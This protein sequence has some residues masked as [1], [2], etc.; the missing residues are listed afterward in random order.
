L[1]EG[2]CIDITDRWLA[3]EALKDSEGKYRQ[4]FENATEGIYQTTP[5]GRY[6]RM[7]PSFS[8][9]F[10]YASP[11]EMI[12][13]ITDIGRQLYVNPE[14][15]K[16][17]ARRL[18]EHNEVTDYE[19]EVYRKDGSRF[20]ISI[21]IHTVR[22]SV[23]NILY[24]E[25][26][27]VDIT[28][29]KMAEEETL[30]NTNRVQ[31]QNNA[32]M[33][34]AADESIATGDIIRVF[35]I[36]TKTAAEA[37]EV[38]RASIWL[39]SEDGENLY[40]ADLY[41]A[42]AMTHTQGAILKQADYPNYFTAI[43]NSRRIVAG[44][45]RQDPQTIEFRDGYLVPLG[46]VSML[47]VGVY[48][49]GRLAGIV[50]F[51]HRGEKRKWHADEEAFANAVA[52]LAS[53][54]LVNMERKRA[55]EATLNE[56]LFTKT[57]LDSLPGIFYLYT[58]PELR[59]AR[60]N[61]NHEILLGYGP[62]EINNRYIMDWHIPEA[63][64]AV[65]QAVETVMEKGFD[66]IE[67]PLLSKDGRP[68]PFIMTGVRFDIMGK[69]YLMGV[70][71]D[72]TERKRAEEA[73]KRS[74]AC[75]AAAQ[76]IAHVGNWE[77]DIASQT[78]ILSDELSRILGLE[79]APGVTQVEDLFDIVHPDDRERT[80]KKRAEYIVA[81]RSFRDEYRI[82][83]PDGSIRW[84]EVHCS[85][86]LDDNGNLVRDIGTAQDITERKLAELALCDA[87]NRYRLLFDESPDGILII[88]PETGRFLDFNETAC[89]QLGYSREEFA[90]LTLADFLVEEKTEDIQKRQKRI[91][92]E[93]RD[94]FECRSRTRQGE[95]RNMHVTVQA[96]EISGR[97][98]FHTV[99]RDITESRKLEN[100]L[101]QAQKIEGLGQMAGGIAHDFNNVL[102]AVMGLTE[103][104]IMDMAEDDP[105]RAHAEEVLKAVM[106]GAELTKQ[107]LSFSRQQALEI[108]PINVNSAI[109]DLQRM[110]RRLVREDITINLKLSDE[111]LTVMADK[112]QIDQV[113]MNLSTNAGDAMPDGGNINISTG[114]FVMDEGFVATHGYGSPG[115]Y[116]HIT[117]SDTGCGM[118]A[119]TM[120]NIFDPFF[121]TKER[122]KGTGLGLA[123]VHGILKQHNGHI[124]VY[125][126]PGKGTVFNLYLPLTGAKL[127]RT[128]M[129][130]RE[131]PRGGTETLL[132]A[133][134]D[135]L[136]R[137]I[138]VTALASFG[139]KII[140]SVD[141]EDA[142]DKFAENSDFVSLVILDGIM[143]KKNGMEV[144]EAIRK[145][146]PD[147]KAIFLSGYTDGSFDHKELSGMGAI[148]M[149]K[150]VK[151]TELLRRVR[152]M[153]D[154]M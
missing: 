5:E 135:D 116:A 109:K 54:G 87:E 22:D 1:I 122:G 139:Y 144:F 71:I 25:G 137:E 150:P 100:Q 130:S 60:W 68:V 121:T 140:E 13:S 46:I 38:D 63:R 153:L 149:Q 67:S 50:C 52:S 154:A 4:I 147:I 76:A 91:M 84:I 108:K 96:T 77:C 117:F 18:S 19:A 74:E 141:G 35:S 124:N 31:R 129:P 17:M 125:S 101:R 66:M 15:R 94:D 53:Q 104:S 123:V 115:N 143:P 51:E 81:K 86:Q 85:P 133:E 23:G 102:N 6:L 27:N 73:L 152:E 97:R 136:V 95:I 110:L 55:D 72:I 33:R 70:G 44:D 106:R 41:E 128:A 47:D 145:L 21:N 148:F 69:S 120:A 118:D 48:L 65:R 131:K 49:A 103:L 134:D 93:G 132:I 36:L 83:R 3:E 39:L 14:D 24:Y 126:E 2:F 10:G 7:N 28:E 26:T 119:E 111:D 75:L 78:V 64:E 82:V 114:V 37:I 32:I 61:R 29:R 79:P 92:L 98:V 45:A 12:S 58:Y 88:D 62:G 43:R 112:A 57:L 90:E 80:R 151:P 40:C 56:Q 59:L 30:K 11:Q 127:D 107:I 113:L 42:G 34:L 9:M 138:T 89:G 105:A 99:A 8:K 142:I 146:R 20:W 16:E